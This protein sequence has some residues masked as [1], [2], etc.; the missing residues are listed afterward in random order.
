[1]KNLIGYLC[2]LTIPFHSFADD[3][4]GNKE[5]IVVEK[6]IRGAE[7]KGA[8]N[9]RRFKHCGLNQKAEIIKDTCKVL[10]KRG[11]YPVSELKSIKFNEYVEATG[12][13]LTDGL[14]IAIGVISGA[15]I[16]YHG[17]TVGAA[18]STQPMVQAVNGLFGGVFALPFGAAPFFTGVYMAVGKKMNPVY[19]YK[20]ASLLSDDL[21]EDK[22]IKL[23]DKEIL[24]V[25]DMLDEL[26][27]YYN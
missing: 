10:G 22:L 16:V 24:E 7:Y 11:L 8:V 13:T 15:S 2:L 6:I 18:L 1:M 3:V 4:V 20:Q 25:A 12:K 19:Q 26:L 17:A 21:I 9:A 23:S 5:I 27:D 14:V